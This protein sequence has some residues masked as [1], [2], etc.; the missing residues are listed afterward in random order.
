MRL[1]FTDG[2][3]S[4]FHVFFGILAVK[5]WILWPIF[6]GYQLWYFDMNSGIDVLEF[7]AGYAMAVYLLKGY[8]YVMVT[9]AYDETN[10]VKKENNPP[11]A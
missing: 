8:Q 1:P 9:R 7:V 4:F 3:N 6:V 10:T 11:I 5:F 2:L